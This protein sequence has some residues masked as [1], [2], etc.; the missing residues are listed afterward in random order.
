MVRL[1]AKAVVFVLLLGLAAPAPAAD[2]LLMF[3]LSV[4]REV[5]FAAA[6]R[7]AAAPPP[8]EPA[9]A[10]TAYP[11]TEVEPAHV[12]RLIDEGFTY[13]SAAQRAEVFN[14]LHGELMNPKNA[15]VRAPMIEYFAQKAI[16]VRMA[17][18]QLANLSQP[19]KAR[20]AAD[21]RNQVADLPNE[22][23]AQLAE[24]L[25]RQ[26]LPV[27]YDLNEMLLAALEAR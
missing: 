12:K 15:A 21:F 24:L 16:A 10:V 14:S 9:A 19:E 7:H 25:R 11:G 13:L 22:E 26:V 20:L 4:A 3:L 2:P 17:Q 1:A 23:A 5:I 27:P 18:E 6:R 8:P